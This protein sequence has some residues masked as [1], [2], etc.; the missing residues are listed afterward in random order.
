MVLE[1]EREHDSQWSPIR[2]IAA[3]IGCS[4]ETLRHWVRAVERDTGRRP[5]LTTD[6][7]QRSL[8]HEL[9]FRLGCDEYLSEGW[10]PPLNLLRLLEARPT[11]DIKSVWS[12][13]G[14][15]KTHT[16]FCLA[17]LCGEWH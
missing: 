10:G 14:G 7:R 1:H 9:G 13:W 6:E 2:S 8:N 15:G 3:K 12:W 16:V 11:K 5:G 17:N 4:S